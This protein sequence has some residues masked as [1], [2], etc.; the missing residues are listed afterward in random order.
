MHGTTSSYVIEPT[1][2]PSIPVAGTDK[3]FPVHRVYCVG[4]NYAA[5]AVEMGHDPNKEPPFFFQKNPDNLNVSGEFPYPPAS[6]DVHHEIEM[7]V[8]LKSGGTDIPVERAL[9]CVFGYGVGL[10]M[11]R[12]DLQGKAKDMG[13]PWE[14]GK[15][16]EASA[17]CT[18]LVPASSIGHPTQGAIW[19]DVNGERKQTGDLNQMIWKVPE[20]ISYLSGLFTLMPGDI[21]LSG[22]PAGVGAVIRGDVLRGH[23]DGVGDLE[24]RVV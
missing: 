5:H 19:L 6:N 11:T 22:T 3:M 20:M 10:D 1:A 16:F 2:I 15:A 13:R 14:V 9:D 7:V 8:A 24:V 4:R 18:P 23:I 21:I 12:R 17:P